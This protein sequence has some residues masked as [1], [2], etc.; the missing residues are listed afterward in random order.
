MTEKAGILIVN[1]GKDPAEGRW[2]QICLNK[3][4]ENTI[5][6]NHHIYLWNNNIDDSWVNQLTQAITNLTLINA[7]PLKKLQHPHA[8]PLQYLYELAKTDKCKYIIT[9]DS[10]A[11]PIKK[12]W[13]K[14]MI[15]PLNTNTAISGVWRDELKEGIPPYA[16]PSCLCT[17]VDFID[18]N[19]LRLDFIAE[20]AGDINHDTMSSFTDKALELKLNIHKLYR[21]NINEIHRLL[22]G[23]Y[24]D[25]I[26]HHGAG[27]RQH[28]GFHDEKKGGDTELIQKKINRKVCDLATSLIFNYYEKY[29]GWLQGQLTNTEESYKN[30]IIFIVGMHRSGTSCLAGCL[31]RCGLFL[32]EI[33]RSNVFNIKG[34]YELEEVIKIH[35]DIL[36]V[37]NGNWAKIPN[38]IHINQEQKQMIQSVISQ[39]SLHSPWGIK[40]PRLLLLI[41]EWIKLIG[42]KKKYKIVGTFRDPVAVAKSLYNRNKIT[43][44]ES[45]QIWTKYNSELV[46][47]HKLYKFPLVEFD[48]S[49][50][51]VYCDIISILAIRLGLQPD[52]PQLQLFIDQSLNHYSPK[53]IEVPD[54]CKDNYYYLQEYSCK[55][56]KL[57]DGFEALILEAL[58]QQYQLDQAKKITFP[59]FQQ[60]IKKFINL[61]YKFLNR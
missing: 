25:I 6:K 35:D 13:L 48:L 17:T 56:N 18:K 47:L 54:I 20:S 10:D 61:K 42:A 2:L 14:H 49:N 23:I 37:N 39:L 4:I 41:D 1:G 53:K 36:S 59:L 12:G 43:K 9:M 27:S 55:F 44:E 3:I 31:E 15:T 51:T 29:I 16:H 45:Y 52:I 21:S 57:N 30:E 5:W 7:N 19:H 28:I 40:D 24:G 60:V 38:H 11:H 32:G 34:N 58:K 26:Y 8:V 22:G 46:R 50:P 33:S